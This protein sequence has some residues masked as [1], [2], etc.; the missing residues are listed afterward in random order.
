MAGENEMESSTVEVG[1]EI[2][3]NNLASDPQPEILRPEND[4]DCPEELEGQQR[5]SKTQE[6][7]YLQESLGVVSGQTEPNYTRN[8]SSSRGIAALSFVSLKQTLYDS[9]KDTF[10]AIQAKARHMVSQN[11]RRYQVR[12]LS[13]HTLYIFHDAFLTNTN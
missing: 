1:V 11:K 4:R 7:N 9:S 3:E 8:V 13:F 12:L 5:P 10:K 6:E 2:G